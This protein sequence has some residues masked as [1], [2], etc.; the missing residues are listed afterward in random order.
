MAKIVYENASPVGRLYSPLLHFDDSFLLQEYFVPRANFGHFYD[1]MKRVVLGELQKEVNIGLVKMIR[2]PFDSTYRD[3][4][5]A[6]FCVSDR[7]RR[8]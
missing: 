1:T 5:E 3:V 4:L 2:D 8:R 7:I 6:L